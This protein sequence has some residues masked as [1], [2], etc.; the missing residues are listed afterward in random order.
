MDQDGNRWSTIKL[1]NYGSVTCLGTDSN[2]K[3]YVGGNDSFGLFM[4][5]YW[6]YECRAQLQKSAGNW[7]AFWIQSPGIAQG[8]DLGEFGTE[9]G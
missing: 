4:T 2:G 1:L 7:S 8:E 9:I 6:Y 5:T 3:V